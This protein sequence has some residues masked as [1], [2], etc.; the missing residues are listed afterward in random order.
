[1]NI[2]GNT[3]LITGG[4]T[5]IGFALAAEFASRG[6]RVL[7]CGR[8]EERLKAAGEKIPGLFTG[9][10]DVSDPRGRKD[11]L[12]WIR[13]EHPELN[14]LVNNAGIQRPV[15]LAAGT[16]DI[17]KGEDEIDI[18]F[19]SQVFLTALFIPFLKEKEKA[20]IINITSGLGFIPLARYPL[21]SAS[22]AAFHSYTLSLRHQLRDTTIKVFEAI[23]PTVFDT[24]LKGFRMDRNDWSISSA[25]MAS[26]IMDG[27]IKDRDEITAGTSG[28]WVS[29]TEKERDR[30]F[31]EINR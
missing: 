26:A 3:V 7:I 5:G 25:E 1:M 24:E 19:R 10:C 30:I 12:E 18:N 15:D 27:L 8:R 21:Y 16:D 29:C 13:S 14:V 11:L 20:A 4:G 2:N 28:Y 22:K 31:H 23:P 9:R 17:E 6:N